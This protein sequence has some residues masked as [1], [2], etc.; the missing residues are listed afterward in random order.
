MTLALREGTKCPSVK[1]GKWSPI[2]QPAGLKYSFM[3]GLDELWNDCWA[4][5]QHATIHY[6]ESVT[7]GMLPPFLLVHL[8]DMSV[9]RLVY[10]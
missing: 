6:T 7:M 1:T 10:D 9:R 5:L 8:D 3:R 4:Q 2:R